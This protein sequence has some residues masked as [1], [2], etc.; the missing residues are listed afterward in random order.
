MSKSRSH[1][2]YAFIL[3]FILILTTATAQQKPEEKVDVIRIS[4]ELVQTHITVLD[5]K[6]RF[7][8]GLRP[9]QFELQVDG[10]AKGISF[11]EEVTAGGSLDRPLATA[12]P[13]K[14][15]ITER[16]K[17]PTDQPVVQRRTVFFFVDDMHL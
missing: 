17:P 5:K 3:S 4:T 7:V 1:N 9:D 13:G 6:G 11:F 12:D 2:F 8:T 15:A 16:D 10:K 14:R